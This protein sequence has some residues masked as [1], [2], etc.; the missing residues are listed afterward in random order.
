MDSKATTDQHPDLDAVLAAVCAEDRLSDKECRELLRR[1]H[2][3]IHE[4]ENSSRP[5]PLLHVG[6]ALGVAAMV[7]AAAIAVWLL[8]L[9]P[10]G[11]ETPGRPIAQVPSTRQRPSS[12]PRGPGQVT[13]LRGWGRY[14]PPEPFS[15]AVVR[16]VDGRELFTG[17]HRGIPELWVVHAPR[18][19][20]VIPIGTTF[21]FE[22][23]PRDPTA[24]V[25]VREGAV[26]VLC[27]SIP[28][29]VSTV[30]LGA[31][32][33]GTFPGPRCGS[34]ADE[35][36]TLYQAAQRIHAR[37]PRDA[38][39][40]AILDRF[41]RLYP[42]HSLF[43]SATLLLGRVLCDQGRDRESRDLLDQAARVEHLREAAQ[44]WRCGVPEGNR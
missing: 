19:V 38:S 2:R 25:W 44:A 17:D 39:A 40:A 28:Y 37:N 36:V 23:G 42:R 10:L 29:R 4:L 9:R 32:E 7:A 1:A 13:T 31:G 26:L 12:V 33:S 11:H 16:E 34:E 3:Q 21:E 15:T 20:T 8:P 14:L 27:H 22:S 35:A 41:R 5:R 43:A 30:V 18:T 6:G 24:T